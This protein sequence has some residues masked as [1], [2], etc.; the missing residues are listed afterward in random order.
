MGVLTFNISDSAVQF[1]G[2]SI[3]CSFVAPSCSRLPQENAGRRNNSRHHGRKELLIYEISPWTISPKSVCHRHWEWERAYHSLSL[4]VMSLFIACI[5]MGPTSP[6]SKSHE[7]TGP[8]RRPGYEHIRALKIC[9]YYILILAGFGRH[10]RFGTEITLVHS[11][12]KPFP[13]L[14]G[15]VAHSAGMSTRSTS[16]RPRRFDLAGELSY[17]K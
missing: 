1:S 3:K 12:G 8:P 7:H 5:R 14:F 17:G 9:V 13:I 11:S 10:A 6:E 2:I 15:F 4:S 16:S